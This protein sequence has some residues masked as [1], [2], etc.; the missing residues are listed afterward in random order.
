MEIIYHLL[1]MAPG[2]QGGIDYSQ[3]NVTIIHKNA[4]NLS[5]TSNLSNSSNNDLQV[6]IATPLLD[7]RERGIALATSP[8]AGALLITG[9]FKF[10]YFDREIQDHITYQNLQLTRRNKS[11]RKD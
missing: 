2:I 3:E 11:G 8:P 7:V 6:E 5:N 9:S 4:R 1:V 10:P